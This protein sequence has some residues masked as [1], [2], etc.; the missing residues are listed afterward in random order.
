MDKETKSRF[1]T[2]LEQAK[3]EINITRK[4]KRDS[5]M[6]VASKSLKR[7]VVNKMNST[8]AAAFNKN[9]DIIPNDIGMNSSRQTA[10]VIAES[11]QE[12]T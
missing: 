3:D 11:N 2:Q 12:D 6:D 1:F 10:S 5:N 7:V 4:P 9:A 8:V